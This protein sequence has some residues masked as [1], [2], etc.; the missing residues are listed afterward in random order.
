MNSLFLSC[1]FSANRHGPYNDAVFVFFRCLSP[2][3]LR[4][5]EASYAGRQTDTEDFA[6]IDGNVL[7]CQMHG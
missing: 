7:T 5:A 1:R 3:R 2:E 6:A 4:Q